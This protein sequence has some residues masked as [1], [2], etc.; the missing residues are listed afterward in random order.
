M[1][2][3]SFKFPTNKKR[4]EIMSHSRSPHDSQS[5][6]IIT[7]YEEAKQS[8][9]SLDQQLY[10]PDAP[11]AITRRAFENNNTAI[12]QSADQQALYEQRDN[13]FASII[14]S[15]HTIRSQTIEELESAR[16]GLQYA[17]TALQEKWRSI[18]NGPRIHTE[19]EKNEESP[20]AAASSGQVSRRRSRA[21]GFMHRMTGEKNPA[22]PNAKFTIDNA[23][24]EYN[25]PHRVPLVDEHGKEINRELFSPDKLKDIFQRYQSS[26]AQPAAAPRRR[27]LVQVAGAAAQALVDTAKQATGHVGKLPKDPADP[28]ATFSINNAPEGYNGPR[29][30]SLTDKEGNEINHNLFTSEKINDIMQRFEDSGHKP[31]VEELKAARQRARA[32]FEAKLQ[33]LNSA[34]PVGYRLV[35]AL[36]L[37]THD[38]Q[39]RGAADPNFWPAIE[40]SLKEDI[41]I[42]DGSSEHYEHQLGVLANHL[43]YIKLGELAKDGELR[44]NIQT[45]LFNQQGFVDAPFSND[46]LLRE[47]NDNDLLAFYLIFDSLTPNTIDLQRDNLEAFCR[48]METRSTGEMSDLH[49]YAILAA[50]ILGSQEALSDLSNIHDSTINPLLAKGL[51]LSTEFKETVRAAK[52][53]CF[54]PQQAMDFANQLSAIPGIENSIFA[55]FPEAC[56]TIAKTLDP[57]VAETN[58]AS[59]EKRA[60]PRRRSLSGL[61]QPP[62]PP[63]PTTTTPQKKEM[64]AE[65]KAV[66]DASAASEDEAKIQHQQDDI[67]PPPPIELANE[68]SDSQP[69]AETKAHIPPP[70]PIPVAAAKPGP[71]VTPPPLPPRPNTTASTES[72]PAA[73]ASASVPMPPPMPAA[74]PGASAPPPPPMPA[75]KTGAGAPPPPPMPAAKTGAGAPGDL[76][77]AIRGG[78]KLK[79][80]APA[81]AAAAN[82]QTDLLAAIRGGAKLKKVP[83]PAA[84]TQPA[85]APKPGNLHG[86]VMAGIHGAKLKK[87]THSRPSAPAPS[88]TPSNTGMMGAMQAMALNRQNREAK[89]RQHLAEVY[90]LREEHGADND[91]YTSKRDEYN[92]TERHVNDYADEIRSRQANP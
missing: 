35:K 15:T 21:A 7:A 2:L 34:N 60:D 33:E 83:D 19:E 66:V 88:G 6:Q 57:T 63:A 87:T 1:P 46:P 86:A 61:T 76:L 9:E 27:S 29:R 92:L 30:V 14:S 20:A 26:I 3:Y 58:G 48:R 56:K 37:I 52:R 22:D 51:T 45:S 75:A 40:E 54:T 16:I 69:Q 13:A 64:P 43:A 72:Q 68:K 25:G 70:P 74:K 50:A 36:Q 39:T 73:T 67:P 53:S 8:V 5:D 42:M 18:R 10:N 17:N 82:P 78:A 59:E 12:E 32:E 85:A 80:A 47:L 11:F 28:N 38:I 89:K 81:A 90:Q 4:N 23:P 84:A 31:E 79:K 91:V 49:A 24:E 55:A 65:V 62:R 71:S 44:V 41:S 77:A